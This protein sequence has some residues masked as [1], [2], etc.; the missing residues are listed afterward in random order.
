[1][2]VLVVTT[3]RSGLDKY[4]QEIAKRI[5]SEKIETPR[6]FSL[7]EAYSFAKK[8]ESLEDVVHLSN[9]H[10]ARYALFLKKPFLVTVHDLARCCFN[11]D[12]ETTRER[13][14]LKR[15]IRGIKKASHII[16]VSQNTKSDLIKYLN[17]PEERI[18][19]IYNGVDHSIF[20]P[21][22]SKLFHEPYIL[23][24]GTERARKNLSSLFHAF[25]RLKWEFKGLKLVKVGP[26]G[27]SAEFRKRTIKQI[28]S[29]VLDEDVIFVDWVAENDLPY[30]Y[31]SA[32]LL[33]YPSLYEGF[34]LPPLEAMAC[35]CPVVTSNTSS[36]PE[37][38]GD[39]AIMV[40]P[41]DIDG[42]ANAMREV[43][44]NDGLRKAMIEKGLA[45]AKKFSWEKTAEETLEVY[46]KV[47][48]L[49]ELAAIL[50][51]KASFSREARQ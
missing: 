31:S 11:S 47:E 45:Q 29:L 16:A 44:T 38:V 32:S 14:S 23:Y 39:A 43:L 48:G 24:V 12:M 1:M 6:Y 37:V 26:P 49:D 20:K 13:I 3:E 19:V 34:G 51:G 27:R 7:K 9:Q 33:V 18:T 8:V 42:L 30:Y 2:A 10:F 40:D 35:G 41:Y 4:S 50:R 22:K 36:L 15:D 21:V 17:I 25:S 46:K 5:K 28:Q